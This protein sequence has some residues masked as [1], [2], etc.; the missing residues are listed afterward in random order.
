MVHVFADPAG[1]F[2]WEPHFRN[3]F[4]QLEFVSMQLSSEAILGDDAWDELFEIAK[5]PGNIIFISP[6]YDTFSRA[7]HKQPGPRPLRSDAWPRGFPWLGNSALRKV[8][9]ANRFIDQCLKATIFAAEA[10]S[11]FMWEAPEHFGR[12]A[13]GNVPSSIWA[14]AEM[15]DCIPRLKAE[16]FVH[17]MCEFGADVAKPTRYLTNLPF[18]K[19]SPRPHATL[20]SFDADMRYKG[21]L[22]KTCPHEHHEHTTGKSHQTQDWNLSGVCDRPKPF[23]QFVAA[24]IDFSLQADGEVKSSQPMPGFPLP[25]VPSGLGPRLDPK[26][27]VSRVSEQQASQP[28]QLPPEHPHQP[29]SDSSRAGVSQALPPCP[30]PSEHV[31]VRQASHPH[32][33]PSEHPHPPARAAGPRLDSTSGS[34]DAGAEVDPEALAEELLASEGPLDKRQ[35]LKLFE[36]LPR[37]H[38]PRATTGDVQGSAFTTGAYCKGPLVGLRHNTTA[39]PKS[40]EVLTKYLDQIAPAFQASAISV[41]E[42]VRTVAHRDSRNAGHPNIV[43]P[44]TSF[45]GGEIWQEQEG[46]S[47]WEPTPEGP[48]PGILLDV[49][50]APVMFDAWLHYHATRA[51]VGR[52]VVLVAYVTDKLESLQ[53]SDVATLAGLGFRLPHADANKDSETSEAMATSLRE[54]PEP[55][56][57]F[58]PEACGNRGSPIRVEWEGQASDITDGFGLCSPARWRPMDRGH[59]LSPAATAHAQSMYCMLTRFV[60]EH[61]HDPQKFCLSLLSGKVESS[62]FA[63]DKLE[64]LRKQWAELHGAGPDSD[65]LEIPDAQPFLAQGI[66]THG[67]AA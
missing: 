1:R 34:R 29:H 48:L 27:S 26:L 60:S 51:W 13:D 46:G 42:N 30:L 3:C 62:P 12:T 31:G 23:C 59:R 10:G 53:A 50:Q 17:Y 28:P 56:I 24:A 21:P 47:I 44:L 18:F 8:Q 43:A 49:S 5:Q 54:T 22:P 14:W 39:C 15:I 65:L 2:D 64:G 20:P 57:A 16:T 32:Q 35:I 11:F 41:F 19:H 7:R 66:V 45:K 9:V 6:P 40:T 36:A 4:T 25:R 38:P 61:V 63:G 52:R 55:T 33:L 67:R 58:K 37:E